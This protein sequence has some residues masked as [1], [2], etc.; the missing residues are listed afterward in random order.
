MS[1][2]EVRPG[3]RPQVLVEVRD[4]ATV[5]ALSGEHDVFTAPEVRARFATSLEA[6]L[7]LVVDLSDSAFV[8]SSILGAVIG[9]VQRGRD[10][11]IAVAVVLPEAGT[12]THRIFEITGLLPLVPHTGTVDEALDLVRPPE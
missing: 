6:R 5:V 7:P 10:D 12:T 3:A 2:G 11:E 4:G 9:A 8:D 1:G